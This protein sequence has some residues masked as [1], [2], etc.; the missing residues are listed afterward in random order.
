M[1]QKGKHVCFMY[2]LQ[3]AGRND[4]IQ[5]EHIWLH[6]LAAL[7]HLFKKLFLLLFGFG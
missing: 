3:P 2:Q 1:L 6:R 4:F 7:N 5:H